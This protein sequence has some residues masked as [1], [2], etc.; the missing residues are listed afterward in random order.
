MRPEQE[1]VWA[2]EREVIYVISV[3]FPLLQLIQCWSNL[4]LQKPS[5]C[6]LQS[7]F[8]SWPAPTWLWQMATRI[9]GGRESRDPGRLAATPGIGVYRSGMLD[10]PV[11][12]PCSTVTSMLHAP[13]SR[14]CPCSRWPPAPPSRHSCGPQYP[15][16]AWCLRQSRPCRRGSVGLPPRRGCVA[17]PCHWGG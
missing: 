15:T 17:R 6:S 8:S 10:C 5:P 4:F 14:P 7:S 1:Q 11:H 12:A 3:E 16:R 2:Q 13:L 9:S